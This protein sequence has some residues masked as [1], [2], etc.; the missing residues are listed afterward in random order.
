MRSAVT[1]IGLL[2]VLAPRAVLAAD[3]EN[4][5]EAGA[6]AV[7]ETTARVDTPRV[8]LGAGGH[9]AFGTTPSTALGIRV[10]VELA[11]RIWSLGLEGRY[12]LALQSTLTSD[13]VA[14]RTT[15]A[16]LSFVPCLRSSRAWACGVLLASRVTSEG[17]EAGSDPKLL[18][19][20]GIRFTMHLALPLD[21]ALRI[22]GELL[23][24]PIRYELFAHGHRVYGSSILSAMIGPTIVHA[25]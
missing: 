1:L 21:S 13:G 9:V 6:A 8:A 23:T 12:E 22:T 25:F 19:G 3:G 20:A 14:T 5:T 15:L 10:S 18:L 24:H 16:G 17:G 11:N 2:A 4:D 7:A